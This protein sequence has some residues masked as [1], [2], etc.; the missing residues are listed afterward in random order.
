MFPHPDSG[1]VYKEDA[2]THL[3]MLVTH[4]YYYLAQVHGSLGNTGKS[5]Q[6]CHETLARQLR[7]GTYD[8]ADWAT[9]SAVLSQFYLNQENF[10]SARYHLVSAEVI[11]DKNFNID[12]TKKKEDNGERE[13][14]EEVKEVLKEKEEEKEDLERE[15]GRKCRGS[16]AR[17]GVKYGLHL[18]DWSRGD[19]TLEKVYNTI[20]SVEESQDESVE[21]PE[22]ENLEL[23]ARLGCVTVTRVRDWNSAKETFLWCQERV[24]VAQSY[25]TLEDRCSE[26]VE[27]AR[28]HSQLYKHLIHW[29]Q[30]PDRQAKMYR[31]RADLLENVVKELSL[32]HYVLVIRQIRFEL[33]EIYSDLMDLK[34]KKLLQEPE[35][36]QIISKVNSLIKQAVVHFS[37]FQDTIKVDG[38]FPSTLQ[39]ESVRPALLTH[40][41]LGRLASK[42][43][44]P[45]GSEQELRNVVSTYSSYKEIVDYCQRHPDASSVVEHELAVCRELVSLLPVRIAKMKKELGK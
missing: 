2:P 28:D 37:A 12:G 10:L 16:V 39:S 45:E 18:L 1:H 4:T 9:N 29:E 13:E 26:Y 24:L 19:E 34:R 43:V 44:V 33:G 22:F 11:F 20:K 31:R 38:K 5:A 30:D 25:F 15:L 32:S 36:P 41:H 7:T 40:F 8:P 21:C 27:L 42:L 6:Y 35:N 3:E 17:L 23:G 14:K